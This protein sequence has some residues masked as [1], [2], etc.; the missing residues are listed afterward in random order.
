[1]TRKPP[2][3]VHGVRYVPPDVESI[4]H[5]VAS[6]R[7]IDPDILTNL[8]TLWNGAD[9]REI[10]E[11]LLSPEFVSPRCPDLKGS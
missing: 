10:V 8:Q 1:M 6:K 11:K 4:D 5:P 2:R 3:L 7:D 9:E